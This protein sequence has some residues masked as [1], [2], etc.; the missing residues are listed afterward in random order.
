MLKRIHVNR[1]NMAANRKEG[2]TR[3]PAW[4]IKLGNGRNVRAHEFEVY[5]RA[6]DGESGSVRSVYQPHDP[7]KCGAVAWLETRDSIR[8]LNADT[9]EWEDIS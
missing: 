5:A 8:V 3:L 2:S 1:H 6:E 7:M 9:N 4:T